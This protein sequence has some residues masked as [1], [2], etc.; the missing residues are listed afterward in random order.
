[1]GNFTVDPA[2]VRIHAKTLSETVAPAYAEA[3]SGV[4][5]DSQISAPGFGIALSPIE[6]LYHQRIDFI[7]KDL[8]GAH[9][10]V[11]EIASRLNEV[12]TQYTRGE[13]LNITGFQGTAKPEESY[14]SAYGQSGIAGKAA[15][16]AAVGAAVIVTEAFVYATCGAM[17]TASAL[18]PAF[19]PST[20]A[21]ALFI[22]NPFSISAAGSALTLEANHIKTVI[23]MAFLT[24]CNNTAAKWSGEGKDAFVSLAIKIKGHLDEIADY[25]NALGS[26]LQD[27]VM[28]LA[29]LWIGLA[30]LVG[31]FLIWLIAMKLA[32][33]FP[34]DIP[35][36]EGIINATGA[37]MDSGVLTAI[38]GVAAVGGLVLSLITGLAK[39]LLT[40][41]A[42]PDSGKAGVPDMTE[43]KIDGNFK[44][45]L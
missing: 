30:A 7:S 4:V 24:H 8:G 10:V 38:A 27:L 15:G 2:E 13:N 34:L 43:F 21:A 14:G 16:G 33:V 19:I 3:S 41:G 32:E 18:C 39:D 17:V 22:S 45:D 29:G 26:A 9:E 6:A 25:I 36:I 40:L 35:V 23:N 44:T 5:Q 20:V 28:V 11:S 1:V 42:L 31:P 37:V 12:A